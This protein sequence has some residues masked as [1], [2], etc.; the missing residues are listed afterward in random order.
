[1]NKWLFFTFV[2]IGSLF[3]PGRAIP[4]VVGVTLRL[5]TNVISVGG[6]TTLRVFAQVI[7]SIRPN[8]DQIFS[9]YVDVLNTNGSIASANYAS[10]VKNASDNIPEISSS[11]FNDGANRRAIYD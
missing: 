4:Q 6:A 11:G 8:A 3:A 10:M 5:D 9:W 1:M 2:L 7:P